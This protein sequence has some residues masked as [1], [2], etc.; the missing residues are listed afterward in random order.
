MQINFTTGKPKTNGQ[1][2]CLAKHPVNL[3]RSDGTD[4][5]TYRLLY[6]SI[7]SWWFNGSDSNTLM[8]RVPADTVLG[9]LGPLPDQ[10]PKLSVKKPKLNATK[11]NSKKQRRGSNAFVIPKTGREKSRAL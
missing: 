7:D 4:T 10:L 5:T 6:W 11:T 2:V 8:I 3:K 1:Y 9:W